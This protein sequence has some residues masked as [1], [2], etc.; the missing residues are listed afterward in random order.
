M[1]IYDQNDNTRFL[2]INW[3]NEVNCIEVV[4]YVYNVAA[5]IFIHSFK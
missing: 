3:Y 2:G 4:D 5:I 1:A